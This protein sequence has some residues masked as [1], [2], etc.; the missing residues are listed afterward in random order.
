MLRR[1]RTYVPSESRPS[2]AFQYSVH[3]LG[4]SL[5]EKGIE[6]S[7]D[8]TMTFYRC[9]YPHIFNETYVKSPNGVEE[10]WVLSYFD[11]AGILMGSKLSNDASDSFGDFSLI[12]DY[13]RLVCGHSS[14]LEISEM[15]HSKVWPR[16]G[17]ENHFQ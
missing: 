4:V 17:Y 8:A 11:S 3:A 6:E 9:M 1:V 12:G 2:R 5:S 7:F 16:F 10:F 15:A 14:L 13:T